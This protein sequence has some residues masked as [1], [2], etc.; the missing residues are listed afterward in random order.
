M[1]FKKFI[2]AILTVC[3]LMAGMTFTATVSAADETTYEIIFKDEFSSATIDTSLWESHGETLDGSKMLVGNGD[4]P[5][6]KMPT[7]DADAVYRFSYKVMAPASGGDKNHELLKVMHSD[8]AGNGRSFGS[9]RPGYGFVFKSLNWAEPN[10]AKTD[11]NIWYT[12]ETEFCEKQG[13]QYTQWTVKDATGA[14]LFSER[15]DSLWN[16]YAATETTASVSGAKIWFYNNA[17]STLDIYVDDVM[18]EKTSSAGGGGTTESAALFEE[19]FDSF[20]SL[21]ELQAG[22]IF[23]RGTKT[24]VVNKTLEISPDGYIYFDLKNKKNTVVYKMTYD[25]M[26]PE[27]GNGKGGINIY[28]EGTPS[29]SLGYFNSTEGFAGIKTEFVDASRVITGVEAGK[30]YTVKVEFLENATS[31]YIIYTLIDRATQKVLGT[32]APDRF[33][34]QDSAA[35][36]S[37]NYN[38]FCIWNRNGSNET[39]Y[40]DNMK[41]ELQGAKPIFNADGVVIGDIAGNEI[42]DLTAPVTPGIAEILLDFTTEVTQ[43]SADAGVKLIELDGEGNEREISISGVVDG[44]KYIISVNEPLKGNTKYIIKISK[45]IETEGGDSLSAD[46][47]VEFTTGAESFSINGDGIYIGSKKISNLSEITANASLAV[48]TK[49]LNTTAD[50]EKVIICVSYY[51]GNKMVDTS[52]QIADV[53]KLSGGIVSKEFTAPA[54]M[55]DID[56]MQIVFWNSADGMLPYCGSITLSK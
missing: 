20:S 4:W 10:F 48:K 14:E 1:M 31:G 51:S 56:S 3:I 53:E 49:T 6:L 55:T 42:T 41:L 2:S 34:A 52:L 40:I 32:Y 9:Y 24:N 28:A 37:V 17:D 39:Y 36:V 11:M 22:G 12:V 26:T 8:S 29:W 44:S 43:E 23:S 5:T 38:K 13:S 33:E 15:K 21:N 54:D 30:W 18:L 19:D 7:L 27:K 35:V 46:C 47:T 45:E 25:I 16:A 50:D